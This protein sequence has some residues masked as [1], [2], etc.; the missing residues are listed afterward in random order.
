[1]RLVEYI[2]RNELKYS[3]MEKIIKDCKEFLE[4]LVNMREVSEHS[5][6]IS[7][8]YVLWRGSFHTVNDI[9]KII[10]RINRR[11]ADT[12]L[13]LHDKWDNMFEKKFGWKVRSEGVFASSKYHFAMGFGNEAFLFFPFDGYKFLWS[14]K[15]DDLTGQVGTGKFGQEEDEISNNYITKKSEELLKSY[16]KSNLPEAIKSGNEIAFKCSAYYLVENDK[17]DIKKL[18]SMYN[19][20]RK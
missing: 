1:M 18:L 15:V 10:P 11:P 14:L 17:L 12:A 2:D 3:I 13:W 7:D 5:A 8:T 9:E 4:I 6:K 19:E 20:N 16:R